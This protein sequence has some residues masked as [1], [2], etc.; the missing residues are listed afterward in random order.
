MVY[1]LARLLQLMGLVILPV[2][3]AGE[4]AERLSLGESLVLSAFGLAVFLAGWL[5]QKGSQPPS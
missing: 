2:A 3:I 1:R 4:L 5:L